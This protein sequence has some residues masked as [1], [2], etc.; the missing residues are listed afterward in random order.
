MGIPSCFSS[1]MVR[2]S[3]SEEDQGRPC[4]YPCHSEYSTN[5]EMS[6]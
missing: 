1:P 3:Q 5:E 6:A 2:L 4:H